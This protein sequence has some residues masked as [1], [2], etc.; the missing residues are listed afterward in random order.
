MKHKEL[1]KLLD[2]IKEEENVS[3]PREH[4]RVLLIDGLNLFFRNFAMLNIINPEG[5]HIGGL[6]GFLRSLGSLIKQIQPTAVYVVFDGA[7]SSNNRK[8][9]LPEYKSLRN[10]QRITNWEVF[11]NLDEEHDSKIDQIVRLIQYLKQLPVKTISIDKVEADDIISVLSTYLPAKFNSN[12]FIVSSD[13]D[14]VQLVNDKVVLYRP[15]EKE[16][17]TPQTVFDKYKVKVENFILYKTL[18]GDNSDKVPGIKG[19]GEKGILKRFPELQTQILTL[20]DIFDIS[21]VKF[22]ENIIYSRIINEQKRLETSFK[23]MNLSKP[24][25]DNNDIA[26]ISEVVKSNFPELNSSLFKMLYDED[27]LGGI[28]RNVDIYLKDNFFHFKGYKK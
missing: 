18:L 7:G 21:A 2:D 19:L 17:Y 11:E 4:D 8:N 23:I 6:G 16:Y 26:Y 27:K 3:L 1:F 12:V 10:I 25:V 5:I 22:K 14:F 24:M 9:L 20:D 15:I 28:I 13:Q